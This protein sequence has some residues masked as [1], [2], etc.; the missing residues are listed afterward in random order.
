MNVDGRFCWGDIRGEL[1]VLKTL[2][3]WSVK[4]KNGLMKN[5]KMAATF[6]RKREE[7]VHSAKR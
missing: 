1:S 6:N 4:S 5:E 3:F 7:R 2:Y